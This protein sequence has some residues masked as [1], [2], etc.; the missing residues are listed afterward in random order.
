MD[1]VIC[2]V[3]GEDMKHWNQGIYECKD[4]GTMIA[5]EDLD[6]FFNE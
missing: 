2:P 3:C 5:I 6:E 1:D 4:C